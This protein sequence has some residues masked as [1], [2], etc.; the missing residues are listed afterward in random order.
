V[1]TEQLPPNKLLSKNLKLNINFS[2]MARIP[3]FTVGIG[4]RQSPSPSAVLGS[5]PGL[6][7]LIPGLKIQILGFGKNAQ[8]LANWL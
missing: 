3:Q 2:R 6:E 7:I 1:G 4:S 5:I 8:I